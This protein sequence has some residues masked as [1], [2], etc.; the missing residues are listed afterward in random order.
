[1]PKKTAQGEVRILQQVH[2]MIAFFFQLSGARPVI[3]SM[4]KVVFCN[5]I[6]YFF[7]SPEVIRKLMK[8]YAVKKLVFIR[9]SRNWVFFRPFLELMEKISM[10]KSNL[11]HAKCKLLKKIPLQPCSKLMIK[12]K[13]KS[14][15]STFS[16]KKIRNKL[17]KKLNNFFTFANFFTQIP[18]AVKQ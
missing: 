12:Y 6:G 3:N 11:G 13:W 15:P 14:C 9:Y 2:V 5:L 8:K 7:T 4:K 16:P 18:E 10:K 17:M 1:M